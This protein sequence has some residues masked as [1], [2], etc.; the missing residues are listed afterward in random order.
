MLHESLSCDFQIKVLRPDFSPAANELVYL[1]LNTDGQSENWTLTTDSKG[2]VPFSLVTTTWKDPVY[3]KV[4]LPPS[5][6]KDRKSVV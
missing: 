3:L 6:L 1:I 2:M 5:I 4:C